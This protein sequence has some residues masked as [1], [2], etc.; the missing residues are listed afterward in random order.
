MKYI[1]SQ[2][3]KEPKTHVFSSWE[4]VRAVE[5]GI[6]RIHSR[7]HRM[8]DKPP[9]IWISLNHDW[10]R[11]C[12]GEDFRD[13]DK[14][15]IGEVVFKPNLKFLKITNQE[16]ADDLGILMGFNN[17]PKTYEWAGHSH[18]FDRTPADS[19]HIM[20]FVLDQMKG[21]IPFKKTPWDEVLEL[22]DGVYFLNNGDLHFN[23]FFNSWDVDCI[24][25]FRPYPNM[26][27]VNIKKGV[28]V[29]EWKE[30]DIV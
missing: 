25:L 17:E 9:A 3:V 22:F 12:T 27:V 6:F 30:P 14:S 15:I 28:D 20:D 4:Q 18:T 7:A 19:G 2:D 13:I 21:K 5:A 1:L 26:K 23:T 24:A 10:E 8:L 16:E 11:W 29:E